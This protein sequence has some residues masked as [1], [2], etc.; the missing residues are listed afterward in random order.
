MSISSLQQALTVTYATGVELLAQYKQVSDLIDEEYK[1]APL[2]N[3]AWLAGAIWQHYETFRAAQTLIDDDGFSRGV[4]TSAL[5]DL[6]YSH[7][8]I[9]KYSGMLNKEVDDTL[10][11]GLVIAP[12]EPAKFKLLMKDPSLFEQIILARKTLL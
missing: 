1:L 10:L 2:V 7:R 9:V 3:E 5:K 11:D 12:K 8:A 4:K 6:I